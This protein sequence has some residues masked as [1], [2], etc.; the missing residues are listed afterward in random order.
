ML[1]QKRKKLLKISEKMD[2]KLISCYI[3]KLETELR[4][5]WQVQ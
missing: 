3:R 1:Q 4:R 2:V 5:W